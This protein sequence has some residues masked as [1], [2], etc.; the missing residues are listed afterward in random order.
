MLLNALIISIFLKYIILINLIT[1][2]FKFHNKNFNK[3]FKYYKI[4]KLIK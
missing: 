4:I 1:F 2:N 3:K